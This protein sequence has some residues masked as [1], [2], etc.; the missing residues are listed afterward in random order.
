MSSKVSPGTT[1]VTFPTDAARM[2]ETLLVCLVHDSAALRAHWTEVAERAM[3]PL[4]AALSA[5]HA[6]ARLLVGG[7][8]YRAVPVDEA[9]SLL[10]P[11]ACIDRVPLLPAP[12]FAARIQQMLRGPFH[13]VSLQGDPVL[14]AADASASHAQSTLADGL[15]AAVE[16]LD[17]RDRPAHIP[18]FARSALRANHSPVSSRYLLHIAAVDRASGDV[19]A[20]LPAAL[21]TRSYTDSLTTHELAGLLTARH[22]T[23]GTVLHAG[24]SADSAPARAARAAAVHGALCAARGGASVVHA[25]ALLGAQWAPSA[26]IDILLTGEELAHALQKRACTRAA[27]AAPPAKRVRAAEVPAGDSAEVDNTSRSK[28]ILLQ[29]QQALMLKNLAALAA[30]RGARHAHNAAGTSLQDQTLE[31]I[32]QQLQ[33]Q[34]HAL[35][36]QSDRLQAG[37][38]PGFNLILQSLVTIDKEAKEAGIHLG[39]PSSVVRGAS[40]GADGVPRP[41][42]A[43]AGEAAHASARARPFW[44]GVVK[45]NTHQSGD[46]GMLTLVVATAAGGVQLPKALGL[47]WPN[48]LS[49]SAFF[50]LSTQEV[51]Q[52]VARHRIP[53]AVL[54]LRAFPSSLELRGA[55]SN[56][57]NYRVLAAMLQQHQR[58][59]FVAHGAPGCGLLLVALS[60]SRPPEHRAADPPRLVVVPLGSPHL[61]AQLTAHGAGGAAANARGMISLPSASTPVHPSAGLAPDA[62]LSGAPSAGAP[63]TASAPLVAPGTQS[64]S[65]F[66]P[67]A[68]SSASPLTAF[69]AVHPQGMATDTHFAPQLPTSVH[70]SAFAAPA[71]AFPYAQVQQP[72]MVPGN[73]AHVPAGMSSAA[74]VSPAMMQ[75]YLQTTRTTPAPLSSPYFS[76]A[77]PNTIPNSIPT[78]LNTPTFSASTLNVPL[79]TDFGVFQEKMRALGYH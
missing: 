11:A 36:V 17:S 49:V 50:P 77:V 64:A 10:R 33:Q 73:S 24:E 75:Q 51:Q 20:S 22:I 79:D 72:Q 78:A 39:G 40:Q 30:G 29:Q 68:G 46:D 38:E 37:H 67:A 34:Q 54:S 52:L 47:P 3:D 28:I 18:S 5:L 19:R 65:F 45:W 60:S 57:Q 71:N 25:D 32:R 56:E 61:L 41:R 63:G 43:D 21:N 74:G 42:G 12:R 27:T 48:V 44:Q 76:S 26:R 66:Y 62:V 59:A 4:I 16:M 6:S 8:V 9:A 7:V 53:T 13:G 23:I 35:R 15:A 69:P 58:A 55:E 70:P 1:G 14:G 2:P 31:Q